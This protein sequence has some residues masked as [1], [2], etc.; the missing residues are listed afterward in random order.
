MIDLESNVFIVIVRGHMKQYPSISFTSSVG[1]GRKKMITYPGKEVLEDFCAI[2]F[3][4][5]L[6][7]TDCDTI[8]G[9]VIQEKK[10][11]TNIH[12]IAFLLYNL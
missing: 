12:S 9:Q 8:K 5:F 7:S 10:K 1:D 6:R 4:L 11:M 3:F 2:V